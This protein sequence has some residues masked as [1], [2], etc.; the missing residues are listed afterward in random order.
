MF[1]PLKAAR[2]KSATIRRIMNRP[3]LPADAGAVFHIAFYRFVRIDDPD[4]AAASLRL[5]A[6]GLLGSVIV[7]HEG[8]NGTLAG[9][10]DA[11]DTF[12]S[13]LQADP[14]FGGRFAGIGFQR[15]ACATPPFRRLRVRRQARIVALDLPTAASHVNAVSP[16][17]W[18]A[19]IA[20]DDVVVLDNRN[21][22]EVRLGRFR[23]AVDPGVAHFSDFARH[24]EWHAP[25]WKAA[26]KRVAMYCT[27]GIRC[28]R[29]AGW[30]ASLG[31]DVYQLEGGILHYLRTMPDPETDWE[32][33]CF[34]F[35]NR[36]AL[37]ARLRE[38][39]V[40]PETVF[41]G[42]PDAAWR[43]ARARRLAGEE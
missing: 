34:V 20:E 10:A 39:G 21:S 28:E 31:L 16:Q 32:G 33:A 37:D 25:A 11:L 26:G 8:I 3:A 36:V 41:A 7:A 9:A 27:G 30:M 38:A 42:M 1:L 40:S 12:E 13:A 35:D 19:L 17:A 43:I 18:R 4:T 24:V 22:F 5:L 14:A 15:T 2:R 29:A 23:G 6:R